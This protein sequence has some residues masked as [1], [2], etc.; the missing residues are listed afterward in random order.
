MRILHILNHIQEIG[1]GIVNVA[2]DL[3]CL[4]AKAGHEVSVASA[5]G[6]YEELLSRYGAKHFKL[7]Q[8]RTN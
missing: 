8:T 6:E 1:N 4:Q 5:G 3:A 2:I 7:D